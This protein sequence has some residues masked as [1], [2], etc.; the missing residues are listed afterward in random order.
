MEVKHPD[1]NSFP[2]IL[3]A[4]DE[5]ITAHHLRHVLT[6]FGYEVVAVASSGQLPIEEADRKHPDLLLA[7][8]GLKG[9]V[10][11]IEVASALRQQ[12]GDPNGLSYGI[13][14]LRK[15]GTRSAIPT[16]AI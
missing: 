1:S 9:A 8:I 10:D 14:R 11:G 16:P 4:E 6:R 12:W 5:R 7:D 15:H 3:I 2:R 13:H